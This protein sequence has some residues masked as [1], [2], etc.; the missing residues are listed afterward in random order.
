MI[1]K[2]NLKKQTKTKN[3]NKKRKRKRALMPSEYYWCA[4]TGTRY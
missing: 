3:N 1:I 4:G 2:I